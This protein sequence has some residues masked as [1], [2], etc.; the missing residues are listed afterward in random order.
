M[1]DFQGTKRL[2]YGKSIVDILRESE[3]IQEI[4]DR[5]YG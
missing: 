5:K 3:D 2:K 1:V 4:A